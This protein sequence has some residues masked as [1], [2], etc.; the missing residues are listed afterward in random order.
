MRIKFVTLTF[1]IFAAISANAQVTIGSDIEPPKGVMLNLQDQAPNSDN[2]TVRRG[3]L[4]LSRVKLVNRNTLE[5]FISI[6]D[7]KWKDNTSKIREHH[8]GLMVYNINA[9]QV[10]DD[11][12]LETTFRLGLYIWNGKQW[13]EAEFGKEAFFVLPLPNFDLTAGTHTLNLY[14]EYKAQYAATGRLYALAE[15]D[16]AI[17]YYNEDVI[18]INSLSANGE[19]SYTIATTPDASPTPEVFI[20]AVVNLKRTNI[21]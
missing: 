8:T 1:A 12:D 9:T 21:Y 4:G 10:E 17:T 18:E 16:F 2:E 3:G 6:D 20:N 11:S 19:L 5:P 15:V 13:K 14:N 7:T